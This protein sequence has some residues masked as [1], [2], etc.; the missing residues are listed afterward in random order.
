MPQVNFIFQAIT[1]H[2]IR[3]W[4]WKVLLGVIWS[5][6]PAHIGPPGASC[7]ESCPDGFWIPLR[8]DTTQA[9]HSHVLLSLSKK[10]FPKVQ[11]ESQ[12][13][14][15]VSVKLVLSLD[16]TEKSLA[17]SSLYPTIRYLYSVMRLPL[18]LVFSRLSFTKPFF[19][20][21]QWNGNCHW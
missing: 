15:F 4:G 20:T 13:F 8:L 19:F 2:R 9:H 17:Q 11:R 21:K 5:N 18:S 10:V 7:S 16:C 6:P 3:A 12:V 14:Q 1:L